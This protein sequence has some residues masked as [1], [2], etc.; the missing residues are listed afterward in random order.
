MK[1]RS[2]N[3]RISEPEDVKKWYLWRTVTKPRHIFRWDLDKTYLKT[4]FDTVRDLV[5]VARMTAEERENIPGSATLLRQMRNS[6]PSAQ[7]NLIYFISGSPRQLRSVIEKKFALDGFEPDGFVLKPSLSMLMKGRFRGIRNQVPYKLSALLGGRSHAPI[8]TK[9][10]LLGDDAES[11]AL[12]YSLYADILAGNIERK[13]LLKFLKK[14]HAYKDQVSEIEYQLDAIVH[15]PTVQRIIINLDKNTAPGEFMDYFPRVVPVHNHLQTAVVLCLDQSVE[16]SA[17]QEVALEML[18]KFGY[19]SGSL[20]RSVEDI[21][22]R[23]RTQHSVEDFL[24][25][26]RGLS[27]LSPIKPDKSLTK[28]A[29]KFVDELQRLLEQIIERIAYLNSRPMP[30]NRSR[31]EPSNDYFELLEAEEKR[32]EARKRVRK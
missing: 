12:I 17:I 18:W 13:Y 22:R 3:K 2:T 11:D 19:S 5:R 29:E 10:T 25:L 27:A 14:T 8:G 9:E 15:E 6:S 4:D 1:E 31:T 32:R 7:N 16:T 26:H 24:H 28:R 30:R 21:L 23:Q 20:L